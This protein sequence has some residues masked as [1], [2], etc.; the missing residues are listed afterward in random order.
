MSLTADGKLAI[1]LPGLG[2]VASTTIAGVMLARRRVAAAA[3]SFTQLG[4]LGLD[5][6]GT[7]RRVCDVVPIAPLAD[8]EFGTWDIFP[9]DAHHAVVYA[10]LLREDH[11]EAVR[12]ELRRVRPMPAVV[13]CARVGVGGTHVKRA[14]SKAQLVELLREDVRTF[15]RHHECSRAVAVWCGPREPDV[16][17]THVHAS[18]D[19]F[20]R[21]LAQSDPAIT[22]AQMYGWAFLREGVPF[23]NASRNRMSDFPA[24][25]EL[26]RSACVAVAGKELRSGRSIIERFLAS[27]VRSNVLGLRG[28]YSMNLHGCR[29]S[30]CADDGG[31][32]EL[33]AQDAILAP[34]HLP[35]LYE[36]AVRAS[37]DETYRP[38][39]EDDEGW[40]NVDLFGWLGYPMSLKLIFQRRDPILAAPS[41]LDV[42]LLLDLAQRAGMNGVQRWLDFFFDVPMACDAGGCDR[43]PYAQLAGLRET[44]RRLAS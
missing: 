19:S 38:R 10:G 7:P 20:E 44:L 16:E 2:A 23:A 42:A 12:D 28:W 11:I 15:E 37:R 17:L 43:D 9:E 8:L 34:E 14:A 36:H 22:S 25:V 41:V 1:L 13:D 21:G 29:E 4:S 3:G 31:A 6:Q 40:C 24:A 33:A 27:C 35:D 39:G 30:E 5:E 18:I 26:A 32:A